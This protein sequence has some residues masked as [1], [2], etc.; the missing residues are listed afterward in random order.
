MHVWQPGPRK[1]IAEVVLKIFYVGVPPS[2]QILQ[3]HEGLCEEEPQRWR[4]SNALYLVAYVTAF[5]ILFM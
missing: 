2:F 1:Q 5:E 3:I 4:S